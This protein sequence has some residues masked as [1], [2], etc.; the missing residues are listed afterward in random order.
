MIW[1]SA[2]FCCIYLS[3]MALSPG[4]CDIISLLRIATGAEILEV[5]LLK[6]WL[7]LVTLLFRITDEFLFESYFKLSGM[8]DLWYRSFCL[9][10]YNL[11]TDL[12]DLL[13]SR[14]VSDSRLGWSEIF[15]TLISFGPYV[16]LSYWEMELCYCNLPELFPCFW[17]LPVVVE[18]VNS[19]SLAFE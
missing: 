18:M 1:L 13:I 5:I 17:F 4:V 12:K 15:I 9:L 3:F 7:L 6:L 8:I 10:A 2:F 16:L 14:F 19:L 11:V